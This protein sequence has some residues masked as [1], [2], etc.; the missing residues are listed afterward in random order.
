MINEIVGQE[1]KSYDNFYKPRSSFSQTG[2]T[3]NQTPVYV[4]LLSIVRAF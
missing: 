3:Q 4:L 2:D 1:F